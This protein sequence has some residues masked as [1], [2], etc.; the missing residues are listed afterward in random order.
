MI[1]IESDVLQ[2]VTQAAGDGVRVTGE[3]PSAPGDFPLATVREIDNS[4]Y[5]RTV[6]S[7]GPENHASISYE[8][9]VFSSK[10]TG[11][12]AE[13]KE[14]IARIDAAML[15]CGFARSML[16]AIPNVADATIYRLTAR[17]GATVDKNGNCWRR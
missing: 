10:T 12:K 4:V 3:Y 11:R 9:N 16:S 14:I 6:S 7:G 15:G 13:C 2:L 5:Q 1:D 17:Y 8:I